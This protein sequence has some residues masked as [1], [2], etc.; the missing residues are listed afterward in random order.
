MR[1]FLSNT[2]SYEKITKAFR[3]GNLGSQTVLI[4]KKSFDRIAYL[5]SYLSPDDAVLR[6]RSRDLNARSSLNSIQ[7]SYR[8][9]FAQNIMR[10]LEG[11]T[12]QRK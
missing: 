3:L 5:G 8:N 10:G 6:Y 7:D 1:E 11:E 2:M 4:S 12:N 9:T